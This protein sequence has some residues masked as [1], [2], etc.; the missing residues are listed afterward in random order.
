MVKKAGH[1]RHWIFDNGSYKLVALFVCL[2]LWVTILGR[3]DFLLTKEIEID[4]H[5]P[6]KMRLRPDNV[7]Q[8]IAVR[9]AGTR[10][11]LK[12][13]ARSREVI[14]IDL[15]HAELGPYRQAI[16]PRLLDLQPGLKL[17]NMTPDFLNL[18]LVPI[19]EGAR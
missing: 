14:A 18:Y 9:V 11:A 7:P 2:I 8:K 13:F 5:L 16:S 12:K 19:E 10:M 3:R 6:K 17:V 1:W 4:Y 15:S